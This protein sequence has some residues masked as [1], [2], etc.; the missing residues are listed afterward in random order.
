MIHI[1]EIVK[2]SDI[3]FFIKIFQ[4]FSFNRQIFFGR[5]PLKWFKDD[6]GVLRYREIGD[7]EKQQDES[8]IIEELIVEEDPKE[9]SS[10]EK[11]L[12]K[13]FVVGEDTKKE[14][15]IEEKLEKELIVEENLKTEL[16]DGAN[17]KEK[18]TVLDEN[19][20]KEANTLEIKEA[21]PN[22]SSDP[23]DQFSSCS[24]DSESDYE[25]TSSRFATKSSIKKTGQ[26][27]SQKSCTQ[28]RKQKPGQNLIDKVLK[29][30]YS[31]MNRIFDESAAVPLPRTSGTINITFSE[32]A[33]PTPARESSLVE[34][35]EVCDIFNYIINCIRNF[36]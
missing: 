17:L 32:R 25:M 29:N 3:Y 23:Q 19:I 11:N 27:S 20:Q 6:L 7:K 8:M 22:K 36:S 26:K 12:K 16:I 13:E 24:E 30:R 2:E 5:P 34:E 28:I 31:K 14:L 9:T 35:Q 33:F 18:D 4:F 15:I 1:L 21:I 10:I